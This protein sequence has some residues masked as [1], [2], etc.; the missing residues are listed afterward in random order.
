MK[1]EDISI[2]RTH[3]M[4]R[5]KQDGFYLEDNDSK[6][7]TIILLKNKLRLSNDQKTLIQVG[8]TQI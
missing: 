7:G 6:F 4:V 3:A 5:Y 8:R 1:I 2:S